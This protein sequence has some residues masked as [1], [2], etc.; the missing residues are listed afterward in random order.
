M[1]RAIATQVAA[2]GHELVLFDIDAA[3]D[4]RLAVD[5][6]GT[7][8]DGVRVARGTRVVKAVMPTSS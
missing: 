7:K 3:A 1:G 2:A 4:E 5:L 8:P 6:G